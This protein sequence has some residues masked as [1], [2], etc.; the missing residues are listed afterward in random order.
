[1]VG[2]QPH[3]SSS[4]RTLALTPKPQAWSEAHFHGGT[5]V[6]ELHDGL[7]TGDSDG[8]SHQ[9]V[10]RPLG[11]GGGQVQAEQEG[12][13]RAAADGALWLPGR[14][15][16]VG[17]QGGVG[18]GWGNKVGTSLPSLH[19]PQLSPSIS[20]LSQ[21]TRLLLVQVKMPRFIDDLLSAR[22]YVDASLT[23]LT[24]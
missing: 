15:H 9:C 1:M 2:L 17:V 3:S 14:E 10:P 11:Q 24:V 5:W 23:K 4:C 19:P 16:R 13:E 6:G 7:G 22:P 21:A 18:E 12:A 8:D 20:F